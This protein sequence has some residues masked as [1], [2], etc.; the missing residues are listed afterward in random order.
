[1]P[2]YK[3]AVKGTWYVNFYCKDFYGQ[4]VKHCKRG[5][6]TKKEAND[7]IQSY[8]NKKEK[9]ADM[10]FGEFIDIYDKDCLSRLKYHTVHN[11]RQ[12]I[13][14][15]ILPYFKDK[16]INSITATDI[17]EWQNIIMNQT[18]KNGKKYAQGYLRTISSQMSAIFNYAYK[19]YGLKENPVKKAGGMGKDKPKEVAYYTLEEYSK[20][21][22]AA[23][24]KER[25]YMAFEVLYWTGIRVGE[26]LALT[27]NDFDFDKVRIFKFTMTF[28][29]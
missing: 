11:K 4:N 22:E 20:F 17:R 15:K 25:S 18:D 28:L 12:I 14:D 13:N 9:T 19:F 10:K 6:K 26:L 8:L 2:A 16:K 27:P 29:K 23:M 5:F 1:M 21:S 24:K 7:Y 3:D